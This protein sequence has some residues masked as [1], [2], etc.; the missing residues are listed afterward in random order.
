MT[1]LFSKNIRINY[2]KLRNIQYHRFAIPEIRNIPE[3]WKDRMFCL[4]DKIKNPG[5]GVPES[6]EGWKKPCFSKLSNLQLY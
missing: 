5:R 1:S 3:K 2:K 4:I 6:T